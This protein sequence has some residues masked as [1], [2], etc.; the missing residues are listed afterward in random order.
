MFLWCLNKNSSLISLH[1]IDN[2]ASSWSSAYVFRFS[3]KQN[4]SLPFLFM[5]KSLS[6]SQKKYSLNSICLGLWIQ[7]LKIRIKMGDERETPE[8]L[9]QQ[10]QRWFPLNYYYCKYR[11][12]KRSKPVNLHCSFGWAFWR[13]NM[14]LPS[15]GKFTLI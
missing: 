14:M 13:W 6:V 1:C 12:S 9:H 8:F 11:S 15:T 4:V 5:S 3:K 7:F 10:K 2:W